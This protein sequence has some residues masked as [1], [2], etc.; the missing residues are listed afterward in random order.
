VAALWKPGKE[1]ESRISA[2]ELLARNPG[3]SVARW[4]H[5]LPYRHQ[6]HLGALIKPLQL[7]GLPE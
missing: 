6:E 2:K 4:A 1:D 7:A 3:F 5:S